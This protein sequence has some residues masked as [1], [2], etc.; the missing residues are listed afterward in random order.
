MHI[1]AAIVPQ[2]IHT[3]RQKVFLENQYHLQIKAHH[4]LAMQNTTNTTTGNTTGIYHHVARQAPMK[5]RLPRIYTTSYN[6]AATRT[7]TLQLQRKSDVL[8]I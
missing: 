6:Y 8:W 2:D 3:E 7:C 5:C 4:H 1:C